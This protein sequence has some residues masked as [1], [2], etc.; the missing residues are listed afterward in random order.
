MLNKDAWVDR[1]MYLSDESQLIVAKAIMDELQLNE[2]TFDEDEYNHDKSAVLRKFF[3]EWI[4]N[5]RDTLELKSAKNILNSFNTLPADKKNKVVK[6]VLVI[7]KKYDAE[8]EQEKKEHIC[9]EEGHIFD[10]W[11]KESWTTEEVYWDAG[12]RGTIEVEHHRWY[13]TCKRCGF[14]EEDEH[15]PKSVAEARKAR[16][17]Q[18]IR[19]YESISIIGR[20]AFGEGRRRRDCYQ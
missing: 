20:G 13:H 11:K 15:E 12:P 4:K 1:F 10:K 9:K 2:D 19:D 16:E 3:E 14:V 17:K 6:E 7:L 18:S 5:S 8:A